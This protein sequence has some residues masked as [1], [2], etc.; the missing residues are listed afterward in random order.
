MRWCV[1]C[2]WHMCTTPEHT[3][4]LPAS[5]LY[6]HI[7]S[8]NKQSNIY[9]GNNCSTCTS[10]VHTVTQHTASTTVSR[11]ILKIYTGNNCSLLSLKGTAL[12]HSQYRPGF[13]STDFNVHFKYI[14]SFPL[15]LLVCMFERFYVPNWLF[16][17]RYLFL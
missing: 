9:H 11:Y 10:T 16:L 17:Y 2:V 4:V 8:L 7:C 14:S 13:F 15:L 1:W 3:N 5:Y 6:T 12:S